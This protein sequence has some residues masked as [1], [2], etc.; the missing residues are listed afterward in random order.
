MSDCPFLC[1]DLLAAKEIYTTETERLR[2]NH[3]EFM[4]KMDQLDQQGE[5][6]LQEHMAKMDKL[7]QEQ[8]EID[9]WKADLEDE[10]AVQKKIRD[11]FE[12]EFSCLVE[13]VPVLRNISKEGYPVELIRE[14]CKG[15]VAAME[16]NNRDKLG[17]GV[18]RPKFSKTKGPRPQY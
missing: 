15:L 8:E 6:Q 4:A 9:K 3:E 7:D 1:K 11:H 12:K 13:L 16:S 14:Q 10:E 5:G 18:G 2:K 17:R